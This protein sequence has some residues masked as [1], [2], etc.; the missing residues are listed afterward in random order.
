MR[1]LRIL[2]LYALCNKQYISLYLTQRDFCSAESCVSSVRL[3]SDNYAGEKRTPVYIMQA[4]PNRLVSS[5]V[6]ID[7]LL[8]AAANN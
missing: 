8:D 4:A 1:F 7:K 5:K 6:L 2:W 3:N